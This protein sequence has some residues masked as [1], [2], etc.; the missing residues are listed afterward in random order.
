MSRSFSPSIK[1]ALICKY[2]LEGKSIREIA[3]AMDTNPG[4]LQRAIR[5]L[6]NHGYL[7]RQVRSSQSFYTL[8]LLG[9]SLLEIV[10]N[11]KGNTTENNLT[12][13]LKEAT[14]QKNDQ[15]WRLHAL[16]FKIPLVESFHPEDIHLIQF[17]DHPTKLR[18]LKNHAD[19]IVEF[20]DFSV[21]MTTKALKITGLQ[22]RL[23]YEEVEDPAIL[24]EKAAD[25]FR[26]ELENIEML[27]RKHYPKFRLKRMT[28]N[29]II[30]QPL[31]GELAL[32]KDT[33]A[34]KVA[35]LQ[36]KDKAN[37]LKVYDPDD[38]KLAV[39]VDLSMG[40]EIEGVHPKKFID[41]MSIYKG[42]LD[43]LISGKFYKK[44]EII[45]DTQEKIT[46]T[47][48]I[49]IE[50][51][52]KTQEAK[53]EEDLRTR[54]LLREFITGTGSHMQQIISVQAF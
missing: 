5:R 13:S 3:R 14:P 53:E 11:Q 28:N 45:A 20:M 15:Y 30:V 54:D 17:R 34:I 49:M 35:K 36:E 18:N 23:P 38:G 22:I 25:V 26:P 7:S 40:P 46:K 50:N 27:F 21:T 52:K 44:F 48:E 10:K 42:F 41:H 19:L 9:Y 4:T 2:L 51:Q 43:D 47:Q 6:E 33:L 37:K 39:I 29:A 12:G 32:E 16:Q 24:L 1:Q 31:K 8:T